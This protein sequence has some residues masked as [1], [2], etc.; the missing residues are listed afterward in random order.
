MALV[1]PWGFNRGDGTTAL[2][3]FPIGA[4][5]SGTFGTPADPDAVVTT[6]SAEFLAGGDELPDSPTI[7]R[8]E[9]ATIMHRTRMTWENGLAYITVLPRGTI[10][11]DSF[12]NIYRLL[13]ATLQSENGNMA[14]LTTTCESV[15]FD[16]PPDD[17]QV[18]SV[19]LGVDLLKHPRYFSALFPNPATETTAQQQV[20]QAII[21]AI[22]AYRDS[23]FYPTPGNL[24]M[25]S[26]TIQETIVQMVNLQK[27]NYTVPN[28]AYAATIAATAI[29]G[30]GATALAGQNPQYLVLAF[31]NI[32][33]PDPVISLAL[34][35][36]G[37]LIGKLWRM[38]DTP[39]LAG[40]ELKWSQYY[41]LPPIFNLGSYIED[42]TQ[43]VPNYFMQPDRPLGELPPREG[44]SFP[45]AGSDNIFQFNASINPQDFSSNGTSGGSTNISW[46]R[47]ADEIDYQRTWFK[48][49]HTWIGSPIGYF[50]LQL[51]GA[52]PRPKV[53]SDYTTFS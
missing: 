17:F 24:A 53:P 49:T 48:I 34:A 50:D 46:L 15:S 20:K 4:S 25:P 35:A 33:T 36:A 43:I 29:L 18:N 16:N 5:G 40:I 45:A 26:G 23:P 13:S 27:I 3:A 14:V 47:K 51:Y 38:E 41:F 19:D 28:P 9:Q 42:P 21:R 30:V 11:E 10:V 32:A 6:A 52:G 1:L 22:Q 31:D 37:E 44:I 39:Y 2:P 8:A 7:E 12:G